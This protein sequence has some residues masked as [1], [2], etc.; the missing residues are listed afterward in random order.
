MDYGE[1]TGPIIG[2]RAFAIADDDTL[3]DVRKKGLALEWELYPACIRWFADGRLKTVRRRFD[4]GDG[5]TMERT[6]V[7]VRS[8]D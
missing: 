1:D 3:E 6:L 5:R 8:G 7:K 2:Q 4:P